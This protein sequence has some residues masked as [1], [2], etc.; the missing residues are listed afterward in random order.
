MKWYRCRISFWVLFFAIVNK[1]IR[2]SY[3]LATFCMKAKAENI[4]AVFLWVFLFC[5][6]GKNLKN[7][8]KKE[9]TL[10]C[11]DVQLTLQTL[12]TESVCCP[13]CSVLYKFS[14]CKGESKI[15]C[16]IHLCLEGVERWVKNS[17]TLV[18]RS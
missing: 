3:K 12:T 5:L 14:W 13:K 7:L 1:Y 15:F 8:L 4:Q 6:K 10:K 9:V 17:K 2:M 16:E 18:E 11:C